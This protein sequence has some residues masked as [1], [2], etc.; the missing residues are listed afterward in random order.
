VSI[1]NEN[2]MKKTKKNS[3]LQNIYEHGKFH[4]FILLQNDEIEDYGGKVRLHV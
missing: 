1:A 4:I 3:H 2:Q